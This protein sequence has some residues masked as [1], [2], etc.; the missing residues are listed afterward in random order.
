MS[1]LAEVMPA[2]PMT[3]PTTTALSNNG[4][5]QFGNFIEAMNAADLLAR[6][7]IV[8]DLYR[9]VDSNGNH[10]QNANANCL[11]ALNMAQRMG[12]D[13]L[14]IMQNLYVIKGR[15][16]W[17]SQ[18]VTAAINGCG[19]FTALNYEE[20]DL[21]KKEVKYYN[22][23]V[24]IDDMSCVAWAIDKS[25][26]ERVES[27]A[28]TIEM[29]VKEGW[30]TKK[31]S[32]WKTMAKQMLRYRAA[33]FFGR[34]YVPDILMGIY[35]KDEVEDFLDV[36]PAPAPQQQLP[37][38]DI[39]P[40][41]AQIE[42]IT[43]L[44]QVRPLGEHIKELSENPNVNLCGDDLPTLRNALTAKRDV[45]KAQLE[46]A[47]TDTVVEAEPVAN[48]E[49]DIGHQLADE[50]TKAISVMTLEDFAEVDFFIEQSK[51]ELSAANYN[52]LKAAF[53]QKYSELESEINA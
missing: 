22:D 12:Y 13:P 25:T 27:I 11:L 26:G 47:K 14:M 50:I 21:G 33:A 15:P 52:V 45:I 48:D 41:L 36:T 6:S 24:K 19:R 20:K 9:Y 5:F 30:Y 49:P 10:N 38:Y 23:I 2:L 4:I 39:K 17:S 51:P 40:L 32:K 3:A 34:S 46:S 37:C 42:A 28:I 7:A 8:P 35:P 1:N 16:A 53:N 31:D 43:T 44:E 29:A 18:F